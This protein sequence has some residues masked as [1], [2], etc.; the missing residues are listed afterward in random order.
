MQAS[1]DARWLWA[2]AHVV[3]LSSNATPS[4]AQQ[5]TAQR[6][7]PSPLLTLTAILLPALRT[8]C[9]SAQLLKFFSI[10]LLLQ[11]AA[12]ALG[13][14]PRRAAPLLPHSAAPPD[15]LRQAS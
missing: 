3:T 11:P 5:A 14:L 13:A 15:R 8:H 12:L 6:A 9:A 2:A 1:G 7:Q 10:K 4:A